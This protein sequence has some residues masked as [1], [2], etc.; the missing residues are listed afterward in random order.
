MDFEIIFH[1]S[2]NFMKEMYDAWFEV[3]IIAFTI[4]FA[5]DGVKGDTLF[6]VNVL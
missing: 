3:R 5:L 1:L 6:E 4:F 2:L